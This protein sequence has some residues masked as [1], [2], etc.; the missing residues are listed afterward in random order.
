[1][2]VDSNDHIFFMHNYFQNFFCCRVFVCFLFRLRLL[3]ILFALA[4]SSV[5]AAS[6]GG[7]SEAPRGTPSRLERRETLSTQ[8]RHTER[9]RNTKRTIQAEN[10]AAAQKNLNLQERDQY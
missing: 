2:A 3:S 1:M 4:R 8:K 5:L 7:L 9:R 10:I 6:L